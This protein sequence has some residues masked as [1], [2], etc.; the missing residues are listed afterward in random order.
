M[1][2]DRCGQDSGPPMHESPGSA[3]GADS[4]WAGRCQAP[5]TYPITRL[6]LKSVSLHPGFSA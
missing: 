1:D 2:L 3:P 4:N 6:P 5:P